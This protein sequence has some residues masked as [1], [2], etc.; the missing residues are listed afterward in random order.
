[1]SMRAFDVAEERHVG[2]AEADEVRCERGSRERERAALARAGDGEPRG[3]DAGQARGRLDGA[4]GV[5]VEPAVVVG[6]GRWR[7][8]RV[9]TPGCSAPEAPAPGSGVSPVD[10]VPPCARESMTNVA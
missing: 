2:M 10:Q 7:S 9:M 6:L 8:P 4:H 5:D 3:V 1:M